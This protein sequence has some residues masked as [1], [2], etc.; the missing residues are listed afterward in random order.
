MNDIVTVEVIVSTFGAI[1]TV[2][3]DVG[4]HDMDVIQLGAAEAA[5]RRVLDDIG[6]SAL[7]KQ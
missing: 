5:R 1:M 7:I 2:T 4:R 6:A 3:V